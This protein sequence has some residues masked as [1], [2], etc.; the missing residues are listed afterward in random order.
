MRMPVMD[1]YAATKKIRELPKGGE[2]KIVAVTA[3]VLEE[4]RE[5]ILACGCNDLVR[6]P[7]RYHEFFEAMARQLDIKYLYKEDPEEPVQKQ[8]IDLTAE[9]LAG[10]PP[11]LHQEL[12]ETMLALDREA[13]LKVVERIEEH[14]SDTAAGLR[15]L[16][17]NLQ[18]G[19]IRELLK[20]VE[21]E[22]ME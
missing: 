21:G 22:K 7:F 14:A 16:V 2:V 1:G 20:E 6:K 9:M 19:R 5:K 3:S 8:G 11:K 18:M 4:H 12:R 10:L 13:I 15:S 17:R